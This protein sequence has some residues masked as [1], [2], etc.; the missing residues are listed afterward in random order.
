MKNVA[1]I[2]SSLKGGGAERVVS[3]ITMNLPKDKYNIYLILFDGSSIEYSYGGELI[4][5]NIKANKNPILKIVNFIRRYIKIKD[6][7][8]TYDIDTSISFLGGPNLLNI[9]TKKRNK[10]I[11]S[12]RSYPSNK[13]KDIYSIVGN[14]LIRRLYNN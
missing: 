2:I 7:N 1:I 3:N 6:I 10:A 13:S 5:L 9:I 12:L 14:F 11:V 4:N 8:K